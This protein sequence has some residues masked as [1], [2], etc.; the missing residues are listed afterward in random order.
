MPSGTQSIADSIFRL[1][2]CDIV[3]QKAGLPAV[4]E[5]ES[6]VAYLS[7][8]RPAGLAAAERAG[9]AITGPH[10]RN[11]V[12]DPVMYTTTIAAIMSEYPQAV[13][14]RIA[15]PRTGIIRRIRFLPRPAEIAEFCDEEV[16]RRRN[17][18]AKAQHVIRM[19]EQRRVAADNETHPAMTEEEKAARR[20][21]VSRLLGRF[22]KSH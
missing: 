17:L 18:I 1:D 13:L 3:D 11:D 12:E 19:H 14:D 5:C 8:D 2:Q 7:Q 9:R 22:A 21:Q 4:A 6:I 10:P 20:E 15:D 16:K